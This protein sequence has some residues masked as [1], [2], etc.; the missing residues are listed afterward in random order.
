MTFAGVL[1][2]LGCVEMVGVGQVR[3]V[4]SRFVVAVEM[5]LGGFVVMACGVLVVFRCLGVMVGCL[6]GHGRL[7]SFRLEIGY[8]TRRELLEMPG[9]PKMPGQRK[10]SEILLAMRGWGIGVRTAR[11]GCGAAT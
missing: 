11:G 6:A 2:M 10:H 8:S 3:V 4:S 5:S 9:Q 7:L 1:G